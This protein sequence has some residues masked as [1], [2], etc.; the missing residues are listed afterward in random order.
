LSLAL[1]ILW[2]TGKPHTMPLED[3]PI[4]FNGIGNFINYGYPNSE[5]LPNYF[6][7]D[8]SSTYKFDIS[9]KVHSYI[10]VSILNLLNTKNI[11]NTHYTIKNNNELVTISNHSIKIAPNFTFRVMF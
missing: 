1:G 4:N 2:K 7:A 3:N 5:R 10:G 11:L 9:K 6:R 8:F